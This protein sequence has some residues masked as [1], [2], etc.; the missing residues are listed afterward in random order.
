M[1]I[2]RKQVPSLGR[3]VLV[4]G[5]LIDPTDCNVELP[6]IITKVWGNDNL[7][8]QVFGS[9]T[10]NLLVGVKHED[11][12]AV[13]KAASWRWPP[14]VAPKSEPAGNTLSSPSWNV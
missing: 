11:D 6:G 4:R 10:A 12:L 14:F 5:D 1:T 7:S 9:D 3:I 13:I 2:E 8:I